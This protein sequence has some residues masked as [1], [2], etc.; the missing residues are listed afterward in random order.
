MGCP[1]YVKYCR[2]KHEILRRCREVARYGETH[3]HPYRTRMSANRPSYK[4]IKAQLTNKTNLNLERQHNAQSRLIQAVAHLEHTSEAGLP[5]KVGARKLAIRNVTKELFEV[6]ISDATLKRSENLPLWHP[7][8]RK[9]EA[10]AAKDVEV[11]VEVEI[12]VE[13]KVDITPTETEQERKNVVPFVTLVNPLPEA[14]PEIQ[15]IPLEVVRESEAAPKTLKAIPSKHPTKTVHT[16]SLMKGMCW[17]LLVEWIYLVYQRAYFVFVME[18]PELLFSYQG[19]RGYGASG[20]ISRVGIEQSKVLGITSGTKVKVLTGE[21][22][23][24][25]YRDN[26]QQLLVYIK[27]LENADDWLNGIAVLVEHL[28]LHSLE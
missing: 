23:S 20:L 25:S 3:W 11:V 19:H 22:H 4:Y 24:F 13:L 27:P 1:G 16:L 18:T 15:S 14:A 10:E 2:H 7:K 28:V 12:E 17:L 26:P 5:A 6:S 8:W 9:E 21:Y